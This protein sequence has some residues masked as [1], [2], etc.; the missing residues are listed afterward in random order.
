MAVLCRQSVD[1]EP[2]PVLVIEPHHESQTDADLLDA[3][4][5]GA[6]DKGWTV[7]WTG[8]ASFTARKV[9]WQDDDVTRDF[10]VE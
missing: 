4:A 5:E 7:E 6:A 9:R 8:P 2:Q 10:W 1:G 3:K